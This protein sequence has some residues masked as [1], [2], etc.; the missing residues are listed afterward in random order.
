[1]LN[2]DVKRRA[3]DTR[4]NRI[5]QEFLHCN[6]NGIFLRKL[7]KAMNI[8]INA[9]TSIRIPLSSSMF[10]CLAQNV[11]RIYYK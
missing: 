3:R 2:V 1:M 8:I 7:F 4:V 11:P 10:Y 6:Q 9:D 5:T